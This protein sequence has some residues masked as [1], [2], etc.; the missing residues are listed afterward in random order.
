[1]A[2]DKFNEREWF[3]SASSPIR[4][5]AHMLLDLDERGLIPENM[6]SAIHNHAMNAVET[7]PQNVSAISHA[8]AAAHSDF[9][10]EDEHA[11]HCAWGVAALSD[12]LSGMVAL[13]R[14]FGEAAPGALRVVQAA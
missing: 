1:M 4:D 8:I 11:A 14:C 6:R 12:T 9:G 5:I 3:H 2:K 13:E 10:L 7:L